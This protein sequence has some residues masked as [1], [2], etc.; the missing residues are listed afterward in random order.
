MS[1]L[2]TES[3]VDEDGVLKQRKWITRDTVTEEKFAKA[4]ARDISL[5]ARCSDAEKSVM[6]CIF[7]YCEYNT[8]LLYIDSIRRGEIAECGGIK[9]STVNVA[10][11]RLMKKDLLIKRSSCSYVLNPKI[12]FTGDEISRADV[13]EFTLSYSIDRK[14]VIEKKSK[15]KKEVELS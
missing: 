11:S 1:N 15:G 4:Y 9:L 6:L 7:Q 13:I 3:I 2:Y 8:N 10:I 14:P 5:L 12:F